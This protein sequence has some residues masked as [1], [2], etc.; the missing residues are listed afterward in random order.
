M[1]R[2]TIG[3]SPNSNIVCTHNMVSRSHA[4]LT[5]DG[6]K[7]TIVGMGANGTK[8]NG[9]VIPNGR[10]TRVKRG[11]TITFADHSLLD[12]DLV[13]DPLR[14]WK[15]GAI[16]VGVILFV[17][18]IVAGVSKLL[19]EIDTSYDDSETIE[20]TTANT[21]KV[22]VS[23]TETPIDSTEVEGEQERKTLDSIFFPEKAKD[24]TDAKTKQGADSL[25]NKKPTSNPKASESNEWLY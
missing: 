10:P 12:W 16:V 9:R 3:R 4:L 18:I 8:V 13:P 22:I 23:P 17:A 14:P 25:K 1:K 15:I 21:N 7:Y 24:K 5:I 20:V 2:I 6:F 19:N 11:D